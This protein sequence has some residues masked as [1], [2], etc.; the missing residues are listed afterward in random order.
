MPNRFE[1]RNVIPS[2]WS[3]T[4]TD[5]NKRKED[6]SVGTEQRGT[7]LDILPVWL[8]DGKPALLEGYRSQDPMNMALTVR[9]V[10]KNDSGTYTCAYVTTSSG[11]TTTMENAIQLIVEGK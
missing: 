4:E 3:S 7:A 9:N 8:K 10:T 11:E 5:L 6:L 1:E 2:D